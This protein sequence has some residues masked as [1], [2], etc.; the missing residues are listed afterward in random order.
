MLLNHNADRNVKI[1]V[2]ER[3]S[4]ILN[5]QLGGKI[6]NMTRTTTEELSLRQCL[7]LIAGKMAIEEFLSKFH[8]PKDES[9]RA[10]LA[11]LI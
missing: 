10:W 3:H 7:E 5:D 8:D 11:W 9:W 2:G 1:P 4:N 6:I